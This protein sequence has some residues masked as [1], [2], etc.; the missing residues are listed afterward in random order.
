MFL[1][2]SKPLIFLHVKEERVLNSLSYS[3]NGEA[4]CSD[5]II[6]VSSYWASLVESYE[7]R[8]QTP[9]TREERCPDPA[10]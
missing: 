3:S 7:S 5:M 9:P 10:H 2:A 1:A 4:C 6:L 8:A